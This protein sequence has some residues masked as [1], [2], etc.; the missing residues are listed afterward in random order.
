MNKKILLP[1]LS[2][3]I[4]TPLFATPPSPNLTILKQEL[5]KYHDS[6]QYF[7]DV[8]DAVE[9]AK[10]YLISRINNNPS[11]KKLAVVFD[12]DET[13][14]SSYKTMK[15]LNF[16]VTSHDV[17]IQNASSD[18][19]GI[20]PTIALY[21]FAKKHHIAIFIIS[22]RMTKFRKNTE[23]N[24][25]NLGMSGWNQL[26]LKPM[27]SK[28]KSISA[29]KS[30]VRKKITEAG[31]DIVLNIGDQTSDLSGGYADKSIKI[32]NPYYYVP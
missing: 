19:A 7:K 31:Y 29:F 16:G 13:L 6:G 24:L 4:C 2:L 15:Q 25:Q 18:E 1:L 11:H 3:I 9:P 10:Q 28:G 5:V 26:Y 27:N 20:P 21:Q 32:P 23:A 22:G 30:G 17:L 8:A 12:L 14:F